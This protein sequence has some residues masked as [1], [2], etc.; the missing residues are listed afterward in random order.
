[1][2]KLQT[3]IVIIYIL[4]FLPLPIHSHHQ[5]GLPHY[6][7]SK[8]YPQIPTMVIDADAEGYTVTFSIFPGNPLPGQTVRI[9]TYIKHNLT[10][11]AYTKP[12]T[13]SGSIDTFFGGN[14]EVFKPRKINSEY[15]EYKMSF[16]FSEAEKYLINVTFE[17]R[18]DFFEKIRFPVVIGKT[19]FSMFPVIFGIFFLGLFIIVGLTNKRKTKIAA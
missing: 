8:D 12:I 11:K 1:M 13:I 2:K 15:N 6:L 19:D 17:P 7:Y 10:G 5:L 4:I 14:N 3:L 16:E 18:K 9:K